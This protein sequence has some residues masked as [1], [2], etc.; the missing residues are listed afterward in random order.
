MVPGSNPGQGGTFFLK[1]ATS[2]D[3]S[4]TDHPWSPHGQSVGEVVWLNLA[5][6]SRYVSLYERR[7]VVLLISGGFDSSICRMSE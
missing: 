3:S 2:R 4:R 5:V 7:N 6:C 1:G